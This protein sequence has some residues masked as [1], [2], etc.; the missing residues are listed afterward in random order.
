[1]IL[2]P[3]Y[4]NWVFNRMRRGHAEL[5]NVATRSWEVC[6]SEKVTTP[7]AIYLAGE[8]DRIRGYSPW[9]NRTT[10]EVSIQGGWA[11]HA[12]TRAFVLE[13]TR[14]AGPMIYCGAYRAGHGHGPERKTLS[15]GVTT[16]VLP[17]AHLGSA[18]AGS[19]FFG[20]FLR[21]LPLE[22]I[23]A[24]GEPVIGLTGKA[25]PH[26]A[27]YRSLLGLFAPEVVQRG[28][29][30]ALTVY[31]DFAQNSF[32]ASRYRILR[33]RLRDTLGR[34]ASAPAGVY[35]RRGEGGE[36]RILVNEAAVE[37]VL[38]TRGFDILDPSAM[39]AETLA[40]R[41]LEAPLIVSIEGS[42]VSH[43]IYPIAEDGT[44]VILQPPDRFSTVHKQFA[45]ALGM[46]FAFQVGT[47][48]E[49]G[50]SVE[51][52]MLMRLLDQIRQVPR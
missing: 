34:P 35:L 26:A 28:K 23:P 38:A 3:F 10:E 46:R 2:D 42:H 40:R 45:D 49:G 18:W 31:E 22:M 47:P 48:E 30:R 13:N 41:C 20:P 29:I 4:L 51:P 24:P 36:P 44:F 19:H 1:M 6:P 15:P 17:H 7:P 14:I 21:D 11:E 33:Q 25:Y 12:P 43:A 16:R 32:K 5:R 50:F 52:G 9:T 8:T 37:T 39:D 27:G